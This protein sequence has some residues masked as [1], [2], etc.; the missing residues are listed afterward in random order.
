MLVMFR[1]LPVFVLRLLAAPV[2]LVY[3]FLCEKAREESRRFLRKAARAAGLPA[4]SLRPFRHILSFS[5]ALIEKLESWG[6]KIPISDLHFQQ[7]DIWELIGQL[8]RGKGALLICSHLGNAEFLRGL[9]SFGRTAVSRHVPVTS[10]VEFSVTARFNQ[11]LRQVNPESMLR[12]IGANDIGPDT[13]VL[14]QDRI[15]AG[16]LVVIAG[17]R[18]SAN[19]RDKYFLFP[20]L[21]EPAPFAVGAFFLA[22]VLNVPVYF[23]FALRQKDI[24][25]RPEY[26][27]YARKSPLSFDCPRREREGRVRELA[28][29][30]AEQLESHCK[31]HPYQWYNFFDFWAKPEV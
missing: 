27:V 16:E 9:A 20:F 3:Y 13:I 14:L 1:F 17:D 19:S 25:F 30:F 22:A 18:T 10:I 15:D 5:H 11:L 26:N 6:G 23:V 28:R 12:I 4:G 21:G 8:D 2:S 24:S 31:L 29:D 7:D